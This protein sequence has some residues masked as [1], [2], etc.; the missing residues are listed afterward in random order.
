[1]TLKFNIICMY[2][3][4]KEV[5]VTIEAESDGF[6]IKCDGHSFQYKFNYRGMPVTN[7]HHIAISYGTLRIKNASCKSDADKNI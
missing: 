6:L 5:H 7:I 3:P 2:H 1:M 4:D